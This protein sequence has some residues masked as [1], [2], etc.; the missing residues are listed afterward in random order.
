MAHHMNLAMQTSSHVPIIKC[1]VR[2]VYFNPF[3]H[4]FVII[5][6]FALYLFISPFFFSFYLSPFLFLFDLFLHFYSFWLSFATTITLHTWVIC[7]NVCNNCCCVAYVFGVTKTN[8]LL[9]VDFFLTSSKPLVRTQK[10]LY[11]L[12]HS[13]NLKHSMM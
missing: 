13:C 9:N 2:S 7:S 4:F 8:V 1:I 6:D 10:N 5:Q 12:P 3:T 11:Q